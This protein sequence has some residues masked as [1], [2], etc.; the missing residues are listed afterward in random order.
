MRFKLL[1][2]LL[3][4]FAV[5]SMPNARAAT[6]VSNFVGARTGAIGT[7]TIGTPVT[8]PKVAASGWVSYNGRWVQMSRGTAIFD[9]TFNDGGRTRRF[10]VVRREPANSAVPAVIMLHGAGS[11]PEDQVTLSNV[12]AGVAASGYWA[13]LP[14]G[15][16]GGWNQDPGVSTGID[17]VGFV[18]KL[19]DIATGYFKLDG[20]RVYAS[21]MSEGGFMTARLGCELSDRIAGTALVAAT[22]SR[23]L[24]LACAPA[25]PRPMLMFS[26]TS[27]TLVPY[28]GGRLG[29]LS[30]PDT[31]SFWL[32]RH[33][34]TTT[35]TVTSTL[36]DSV[37][38]GTTV[39]LQRNAGCGSGREV[40]LYTINNGGHTWPGG[41]QYLPEATIGKT[42]KD[43]NA[44]TEL[45][46]VLS[47]YKL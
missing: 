18:A 45:Y 27:D 39:K 17:D 32:T 2:L 43:L 24:S 5:L 11:N 16:D 40:R 1:A 42:T 35:A 15:V 44:T 31:F 29:V 22:M 9:V 4:L 37:S 12:S 10:A 38:D 36:A 19:I 30:A 47:G 14:Q 7:L 34:C 28:N 6:T 26:G 33:N 13:L 46:K 23:N 25:A 41:Y 8:G 3:A 21:G 20:A